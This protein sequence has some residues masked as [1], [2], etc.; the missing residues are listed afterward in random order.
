MQ[1]SN[2]SLGCKV[3]DSYSP[4]GSSD[5]A[6]LVKG[7]VEAVARYVDDI[8]AAELAAILASGLKVFF[9]V[10][11]PPNG[12]APTTT[13]A[14]AKHSAA[15]AKLVSLGVPPG[16]TVFVDMESPGG[17][18]ADQLQYME[19]ACAC[20]PTFKAGLYIGCGVAATG[21]EI[22]SVPSSTIY[23]K[24]GSRP[25]DRLG[26]IQEPDCGWALFQCPQFNQ[27][28]G[29]HQYDLDA[30]LGDYYK[31]VVTAVAA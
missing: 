30:H 17:L 25:V 22:Y 8:T 13:L 27:T 7:G 9:V 19:A 31:R 23:W 29:T 20:F 15:N 1:L 2:L 3:V 5:A 6:A 26:N 24:G 16:T 14:T 28:I 4:L 18:V 12:F 10:T 21:K 11:A